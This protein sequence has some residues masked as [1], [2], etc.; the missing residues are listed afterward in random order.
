MGAGVNGDVGVRGVAAGVDD[1][2]RIIRKDT[3]NIPD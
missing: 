1:A 3:A 2:T